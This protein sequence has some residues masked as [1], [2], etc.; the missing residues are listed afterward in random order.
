[1]SY[2]FSFFLH[3]HFETLLTFSFIH[4]S[5][6]KKHFVKGNFETFLAIFQVLLSLNSKIHFEEGKPP[7]M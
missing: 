4:L 6:L 7:S 2:F 1:M 3:F 5:T